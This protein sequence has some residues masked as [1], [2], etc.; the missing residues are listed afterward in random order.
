MDINVGSKVWVYDENRRGHWLD[1]W[2]GWFIVGE[3]KVSWIIGP[4]VGSDLSFKVKKK[5]FT[6]Y[7]NFSGRLLSLTY[8][9]VLELEWVS[10]NGWKI[11]QKVG[12]CRDPEILRKI[13]ALIG[14]EEK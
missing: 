3:T 2:V 6:G 4:S 12:L 5:G 14:Y 13:A 1:R 7:G 8:A 9:H 10:R 11:S